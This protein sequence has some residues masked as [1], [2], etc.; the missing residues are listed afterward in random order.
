M[1]LKLFEFHEQFMFDPALKKLI[2]I[3]EIIKR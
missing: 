2:T 1:P 3:K